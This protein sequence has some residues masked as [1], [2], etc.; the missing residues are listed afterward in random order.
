MTKNTRHKN[1]TRICMI[2]LFASLLSFITLEDFITDNANH[3]SAGS[4]NVSLAEQQPYIL[5]E[6]HKISLWEKDG[7]Y[8]AF[9]PAAYKN[10]DLKPEISEGIDPSSI[11]WMYSEHIPAVF[12]DTDSGTPDNINNNKDVKESGTVTVLEA[13]GSVSLRHPLEYIKGRGNT[14]YTEF[15]KKPYQI[16]LTKSVP[17]LGMDSGKKWILISN[18]PDSTLLRNALA[19]NLGKHLG[20]PQSD[21]GTFIDLYLNGEYVGNYYVVE[22]IEIKKNRLS[23]TDL[24]EQTKHLNRNEDFSSYETA[25]TDT[26]KS[27]QIPK[28]PADITGGYLIERDFDNR[29]LKEVEINGSYFITE[30][31]EH[32][33]VRSPEYASQE[34][35][36]YI[37][38]YIQNAENAILSSEGVD[39]NT[40]KS[41]QDFI[42]V[43][44]FVR[45]Y[46]LE[47]VTANYDGGV[48][49]SYFYKDS[50]TKDG[51]LY[52][53]PVWDYDISFGNAPS[54]LGYISTSP[55]RLSKLAAHIDSSVWFHNLYK[56]P[57]V[58][59]KI[60]TC[61]QD[62]ISP[63]LTV[64]A[65]EILPELSETTAASSEMDKQRWEHIYIENGYPGDRSTEITFLE[66]YIHGRKEFL[67]KAWIEQVA[68][69]Q[70]TLQIDGITYA[71][72][73]AFDNEA[74][75]ELPDIEL[76]GAQFIGW[77]SSDSGIPPEPGTPV[78]SD[79]VFDAVIQP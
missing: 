9:L 41:Y 69:H 57:E 10:T 31:K 74:L 25:W 23:I 62:E 65:D 67:D 70:I 16:K 55:N 52:A 49:S 1:A 53:G 14:S 48:A 5:I 58:Y 73:Y 34:Q 50:D 66:D 39:K 13:D 20:L 33:I 75:P 29:F 28:N 6:E 17:F 21:E 56:K 47:E 37:E 38:Q 72:L 19:R 54:Y 18:A 63:Y 3:V 61:Y 40:G 44:S 43:D 36:T 30:G 79:M 76:E 68:V 60:I 77:V 2:T 35:I 51:K 71:T 8:Y 24:E 12:I 64:L 59:E 32:F 7:K 11:V 4:A 45:K 78:Q 27:K 46:L 42:D 15:D 22:K 26:T